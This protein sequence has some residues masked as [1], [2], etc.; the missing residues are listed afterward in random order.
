M[1]QAV[2]TAFGII[3]AIL[4]VGII[5]N[6]VYTQTATFSFDDYEYVLNVM[7]NQCDFVCGSPIDTQLSQKIEMFSGGWLGVDDN[8]ICL[9]HEEQAACHVCECVVHGSAGNVVL[10]LTTDLAV[11]SFKEHLFDCAFRKSSENLVVVSCK[12]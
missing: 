12:G 2:W 9:H 5:I 8:K 7:S 10:N 3:A 1:E 6:L 4:M 11:K